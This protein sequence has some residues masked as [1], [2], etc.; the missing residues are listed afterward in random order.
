[1]SS[2]KVSVWT[3]FPKAS[4]KRTTASGFGTPVVADGIL[5]VHT[6]GGG[7]DEEEVI[8]VDV[9]T[10]EDLWHDV[11]PRSPFRSQLGSGPRATPMVANGKLYTTGITGV[12]SC[13]EAKTGKR[14][15]QMNPWEDL[16]IPRPGF[17][18]CAS[19]VV[20]ADRIIIPVGGEGA[21][22]VAFDA[23]TGKEVWK[24]FDEPAGAA[25]PTVVTR[26]EGSEARKEVVVQ[27]TLRLVGLD[28]VDGKVHWEHP[29][30]FE[31]SG[32]TP[33]SLALGDLLICSTQDTGTMALKMPTG[34]E[35]TPPSQEWWKQ[36]L[37]SYFSTGSLDPNGRVFLITN[38]VMPL[39]RADLK[40]LDAKTGEELWTKT[41]MG[42]FHFGI[43]TLADGK[44][45]TLDDAG[46]L[47][48]AEPGEK[49]FKE[50]ARATVCGGSFCNP[51]LADGR[52]YVRD[53][54]EIRCY[55]IPLEG[56]TPEVEAEPEKP[57]AE[58]PA[59]EKKEPEK[60]SDSP[61][62]GGV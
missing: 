52:L 36:D 16:K 28:P 58:K 62:S 43:I 24:Q 7:K 46:T 30:V 48:L 20:V 19:P 5:F 4:W 55:R 31:P 40:C 26:G 12:I 56:E 45:L 60:K 8:A 18:V 14:V 54:K 51:V 11:Y 42:Y 17:G 35:S 39:P 34:S 59:A 50:L 15:W 41:G 37:S 47:I 22:I 44:L 10:G 21:S 27:T 23:Q 13:Y 6:V 25:S 53:S 32:V 38:Q 2:E 9:K 49:E 33:T 3:K 61:P 29:L 57:A 1:V